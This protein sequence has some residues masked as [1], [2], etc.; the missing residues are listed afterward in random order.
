MRTSETSCSCK[1]LQKRVKS[2]AGHP[3]A[4]VAS[5]ATQRLNRTLC[6]S[7]DSI[8]SCC[9]HLNFLLSRNSLAASGHVHT[10]QVLFA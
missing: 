8:Q 7:L 9:S 5:D 6:T 4:P 2:A 10:L 3:T 1:P